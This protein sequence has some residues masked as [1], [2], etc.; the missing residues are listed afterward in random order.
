MLNDCTFS[1]AETESVILFTGTSDSN[2]L[3][4]KS[5]LDTDRPI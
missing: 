3:R 1:E 4:S 5:V 2:E